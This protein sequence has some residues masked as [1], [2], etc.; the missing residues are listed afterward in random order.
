MLDGIKINTNVDV[1]ELNRDVIKQSAEFLKKKEDVSD[2]LIKTKAKIAETKAIINSKYGSGDV[3]RFQD[4]TTTTMKDTFDLKKENLNEQAQLDIDKKLLGKDSDVE[5]YRLGRTIA[6][7]NTTTNYAKEASDRVQN[8]IIEAMQLLAEAEE[9]KALAQIEIK[10]WKLYR[11]TFKWL[12]IGYR[13]FWPLLGITLG[14]IAALVIM[15]ATG[16][17]I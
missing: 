17:L 11:K 6:I 9:Q 12:Q 8:A 16:F 4:Y 3:E 14:A 2:E 1:N 10:K 13:L 5:E 15:K 7:T